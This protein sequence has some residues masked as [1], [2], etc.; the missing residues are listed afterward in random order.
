MCPYT[1]LVQH[2]MKKYG[3][4]EVQLHVSSPRYYLEVGGQL[5]FQAS[6]SPGKG[7]LVTHWIRGRVDTRFCL[8]AVEKRKTSPLQPLARRY[9]DWANATPREKMYTI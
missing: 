8:G 2:S 4:V 5:Q 9:A 1:K 3:R 6:S 7:G